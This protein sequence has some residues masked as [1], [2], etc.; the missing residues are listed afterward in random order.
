MYHVANVN[1]IFLLCK[2]SAKKI[3]KKLLLHKKK[4]FWTV[5]IAFYFYFFSV[6]L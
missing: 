6:A 3:Q 1:I 4:F 5:Y 2:F